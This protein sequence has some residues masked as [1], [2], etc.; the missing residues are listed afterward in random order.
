MHLFFFKV[1]HDLHTEM[2]SLEGQNEIVET[3]DTPAEEV[4]ES[5]GT[6]GEEGQAAIPEEEA[7]EEA[8]DEV[9]DENQDDEESSSKCAQYVQICSTTKTLD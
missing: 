7:Q 1:Q 3:P 4:A 2:E 5:E 9:K 6:Q 8:Q